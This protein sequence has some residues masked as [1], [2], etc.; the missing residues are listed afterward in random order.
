[1]KHDRPDFPL[2]TLRDRVRREGPLDAGAARRLALELGLPAAEVRGTVSYYADLHSR[3]DG[4]RVCRGTSCALSGADEIYRRL[5]AKGPCEGVYCVGYCD[6]SP[7]VL[8]PDGTVVADCDVETAESLFAA[9][10]SASAVP[11]IR[12]LVGEPI[13]T[14]RIC[15]GDHSTLERA[16]AAGVYE[17]LAAALRRGPR[18]SSR[19]WSVRRARPRG[20]G[21][22]DWDEVARAAPRRSPTCA[23]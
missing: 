4:P 22:P 9:T 2:L 10:A 12:S 7:A 13:V 21:L 16:R 19:P 3:P 18:R 11:N 1:M 14:A 5:S 23:S 8:R 17:A 6:R 20:R 15:R